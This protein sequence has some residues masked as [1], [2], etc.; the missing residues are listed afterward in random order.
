MPIR[1]QSF[2]KDGDKNENKLVS[3]F[4]VTSSSMGK[5]SFIS[6]DGNYL[7]TEYPLKDQS[8]K[9]KFGLIT[10]LLK[11]ENNRLKLYDCDLTIDAKPKKIHLIERLPASG[12]A[13]EHYSAT[14]SDGGTQ[15]FVIETV[16]RYAL[17]DEKLE[18]EDVNVEL[19]AFAFKIGVYDSIEDFNK[20]FDFFPI[21]TPNG[22]V[23]GFNSEFAM[24]Q[25][26]YGDAPF[27][28]FLGKVID[29]KDVKVKLSKYKVEFSIID[30]DCFL[31]TLKVVA[32]KD[33]FDFSK[34]EKGKL[35]EISADI[36]ADFGVDPTPEAIIKSQAK[37]H[38][39]P[40]NTENV[41]NAVTRLADASYD[42]S[43]E[44]ASKMKKAIKKI[45]RR[46]D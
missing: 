8:T 33:V 21:D 45:T 40:Q 5:M 18:D 20:Q 23:A 25:D 6:K 4:V 43:S 46:K 16:N 13:N 22:Q 1:H 30:V 32:G 15:R 44:L 7:T 35:L 42:V 31:G 36:K 17:W 2:I 27:T 37:T 9:K 19:S 10:A 38:N 39:K 11:V 26:D 28:L 41:D 29:I 3:D 14:V 34:I 24:I 12:E